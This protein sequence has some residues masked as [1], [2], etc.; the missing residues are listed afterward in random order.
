MDEE[1][2]KRIDYKGKIDDISVQLCKDYNIGKFI[3]NEIMPT[4]YEDFN[5]VIE[6]SKGKFFV[7]IFMKERSNSD[8]KRLVDVYIEAIR[9]GVSHP[10]LLESNQGFLYKNEI[11]G[12]KLR[13]CIMQ[14]IEGKDFFNLNEKPTIDELKVLA[15]QAALINSM[16]IKPTHIYDSWAIV[17]FLQELEK[18]REYVS[19]D[20]MKLI[21]PL[22]KGFKEMNIESLPH[23]FVHGDIIATNVIRDNKDNLWIID[24]SVGN[25]YPRINELAVLACDLCFDLKDKEK[26]ESNFK[27]VLSEYQKTIKLTKEEL[28]A[29]PTY[30]KLAHAM[31]VILAS[32]QKFTKGNNTKENEYFLNHGRTGI[33]QTV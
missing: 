17:N 29:L 15:K 28:K 11:G 30:I 19:K 31:H 32:Y 7:K 20:D 12:T 33:R 9:K 23:C 26:S 10:K 3:S 4:G 5:Y 24:F 14:F 8:C 2:Q 16:N 22:K 27:T 13:L 21:E 25:Y 6:T 18:K 1:F